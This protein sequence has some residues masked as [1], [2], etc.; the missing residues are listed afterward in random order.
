M[1]SSGL[2]AMSGGLM[3]LRTS[4]RA[5]LEQVERALAQRVLAAHD[6]E[7]SIGLAR[8][9]VRSVVR[10]ETVE[11]LLSRSQL[12]EPLRDHRLDDTRRRGHEA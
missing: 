7:D 3:R 5:E 8:K 4:E 11:G 1:R 12:G 6:L 2:T 9:A 10:G